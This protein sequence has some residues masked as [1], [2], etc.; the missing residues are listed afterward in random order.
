MYNRQLTLSESYREPDV[1]AKYMQITN[2][3]SSIK[4]IQDIYSQ[5]DTDLEQLL[6]QVEVI[7]TSVIISDV[8]SYLSSENTYSACLPAFRCIFCLFISFCY[9]WFEIQN[10]IFR[11]KIYTSH[12][13]F[14]DIFNNFRNGVTSCLMGLEPFISFSGF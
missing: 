9:M 2:H 4:E 6:E 3:T 11:K 8:Q 14:S 10:R 13:H 7:D 12:S 1:Q 5:Q